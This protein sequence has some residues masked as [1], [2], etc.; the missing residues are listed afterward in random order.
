MKSLSSFACMVLS[1][2]SPILGLSQS[3]QDTDFIEKSV[4]NAKKVYDHVI[5]P[6]SQLYNGL[7][8]KHYIPT[9]NEHPYFSTKDW[10]SS[11]IWYDGGIYENIPTLY[12]ANR[13]EVIIL[14][15]NEIKDIQLIKSK[16]EQF[17]LDQLMFVHLKDGEIPVGFYEQA[18][19]GD[20]AVYVKHQKIL[21]ETISGL[22]IKRSFDEK[23]RVYLLKNGDY[24]IIR[25]KKSALKVLNLK[26]KDIPKETLPKKFKNNKA[27][28]VTLLA[29]YYDA[30]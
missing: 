17:R 8:F 4:L 2:C 20:I 1:F 29:K 5:L 24:H 11:T 25:T 22:T 3:A 13:D 26:S 27:L 7:D 12:D 10:K 19:H 18:Y 23:E 14:Y 15:H 28:Y 6:Q 30:H 9:D 16:V 21:L